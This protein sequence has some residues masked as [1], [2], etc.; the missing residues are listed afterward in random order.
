MGPDTGL[1]E[2][3]PPEDEADFPNLYATGYQVTSDKD[4]DYNCIAHA[5]GDKS[6]PW[7]PCGLKGYHWPKVHLPMMP[8]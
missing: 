7:D 6:Q 1:P 8:G 2:R 4:P 5:V 3:L